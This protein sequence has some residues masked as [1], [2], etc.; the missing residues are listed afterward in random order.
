[1]FLFQMAGMKE[2]EPDLRRENKRKAAQKAVLGWF[3]SLRGGIMSFMK[4]LF[5]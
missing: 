5:A 3:S 2:R 4:K 1:M